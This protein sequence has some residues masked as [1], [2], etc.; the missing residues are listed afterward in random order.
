LSMRL[1]FRDGSVLRK[2]LR[3]VRLERRGGVVRALPSSPQSLASNITFGTASLQQ[4]H[5]LVHT[6]ALLVTLLLFLV[7]LLYAI[8]LRTNSHSFSVTSCIAKAG[9]HSSVRARCLCS[10]RTVLI[11]RAAVRTTC[12]NTC[13]TQRTLNQSLD[14]IYRPTSEATSATYRSQS[15]PGQTSSGSSPTHSIPCR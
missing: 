4:S 15:Q 14:R 13:I 7:Y 3:L 11:K 1:K 6:V 10:N 8:D 2:S 9:S 5:R 12:F